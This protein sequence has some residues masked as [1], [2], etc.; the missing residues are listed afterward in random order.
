MSGDASQTIPLFPLSVVLFPGGPLRLRIFETRYLDMVGRCMRELQPFGVALLIEGTEA[1][2]TAMTAG[3]G[4]TARIIDFEQLEDGLLGITVVGERSFRIVA[5][6]RQAD[7][8]NFAE[9]VWLPPSDPVPVPAE[10]AH[11]VKL[12]RYAL[13]QLRPLYD[14]T[15]ARYEDAGWVSARLAEILPLPLLEKQHC[16]EMPEPLLRLKYLSSLVTI[17]MSDVPDAP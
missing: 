16:L 11:L 17:E 2:G 4:T 5:R 9:V 14:L 8:L 13:P 12:L 7:G 1:G 3:T 15:A 6:E 10:S